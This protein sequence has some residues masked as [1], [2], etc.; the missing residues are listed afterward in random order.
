MTKPDQKNFIDRVHSA[1][2]RIKAGGMVIMVDNDHRENEGDLVLSAQLVEVK[3]LAFMTKR[4]SGLLC[5]TLEQAIVDRLR[6][7]LMKNV[8]TERD[9][10]PSCAAFT[11]SID[12][13]HGITTGISAADRLCTIAAAIHPQAQPNDLV[14][15][16][17]LFP[18]AARAD[19]VLARAGHTEG[20]VDLMKLAG[21]TGAA[22]ICEIMNEDGSM[23]R[24]P[25][26][27]EFAKQ[28]DLM[29][30][31]IDDIIQYRTLLAQEGCPAQDSSA[32]SGAHPLAIKTPEHKISDREGVT[33]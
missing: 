5:L 3:D 29:I 24:L 32:S 16:G 13:R 18:L 20:S 8:D 15:P 11:V 22:I 27:K 26:L 25:Q 28:H 14:V 9:P 30:V 33:P 6:L 21:L 12:A 23:S 31:S 1:M 4:A 10:S 2:D 17:H 7:P 19:G